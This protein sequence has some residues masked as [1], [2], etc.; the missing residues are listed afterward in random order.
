MPVQ[1]NTKDLMKGIA[2]IARATQNPLARPLI[3]KL[4]PEL[5]VSAEDM[6]TLSAHDADYD[7]WIAAAQA[8]VEQK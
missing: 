6:A 7:K 2:L 4:L 8:R 3:E 1:I 5:G